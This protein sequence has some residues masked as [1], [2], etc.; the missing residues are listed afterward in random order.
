M[1]MVINME[2]GAFDS[3]RRVLPVTMFDNKLDRKSFNLGKQIFEKMLAGMYLGEISRNA[4]VHLID[5]RLLLNGQSTLEMNRVWAFDPTYMST[6]EA[7]GT[8]DLEDTRLVLENHM[9]YTAFGTTTLATNAMT[10]ITTIIDRHIR[11][12]RLSAAALTGILEYT[13]DVTWSEEAGGAEIGVDGSLFRYYP[14]FESDIKDGLADISDFERQSN[15]E[16]RAKTA[17]VDMSTVRM[18]LSTDGSGVGA[19][20]CALLAVT[21]QTGTLWCAALGCL[22]SRSN[23]N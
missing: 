16:G 9:G 7:D 13:R 21:S 8:A 10:T 18:G 23:K 20:L 6:I 2:F 3:E 17:G 14:N 19:A 1:E 22:V 12:A 5:R 11:A 15:D 4:L